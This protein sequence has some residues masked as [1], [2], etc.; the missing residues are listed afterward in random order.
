[1]KKHRNPIQGSWMV[2]VLAGLKAKTIAAMKRNRE[3]RKKLLAK[4]KGKKLHRCT[5]CQGKGIL[6]IECVET[7]CN[8]H[9]TECGQCKGLGKLATKEKK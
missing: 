4:L 3:R 8:G 7:F 1:M 6:L 5:T 2:S 9:E